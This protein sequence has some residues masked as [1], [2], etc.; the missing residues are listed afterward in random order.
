MLTAGA[1]LGGV[2]QRLDRTLGRDDAGDQ[3]TLKCDRLLDPLL[4][5]LEAS[6]ENALVHLRC[7]CF[8]EREA[9]L[10]STRLDHHDRDVTVFELT[11]CNDEFEGR[12]FAF[13]EG[14]VRDPLTV[15]RVR[16]TH[17]ADRP[18]EGNAAD[19]QRR[20]RR[21]DRQNVVRVR[22]VGTDDRENDLRL[23][24]VPVGERGTKRAVGETA[25]E[26]RH[27]GRSAFATEESAGDLSGGI[28]ALFDVDRQWEEV[29]AVTHP[30][31]GVGG[32]QHR[33][34][35]E[36]RNDGTL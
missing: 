10:G 3:L 2:R 4:R 16:N 19:H 25:R 21:V 13:L 23:V 11:T 27:L 5:R 32:G 15:D 7:T 36:A 14:G 17:R 28:G 12:C 18:L 1:N 9:L 35:A 31:R 8:V 33:R 30:L 22:L 6:G 20:R 26:N 34:A 24:A 29:D